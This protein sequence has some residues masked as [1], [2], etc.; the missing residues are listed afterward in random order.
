MNYRKVYFRLNSSYKWGS[1][2]S[3]EESVLFTKETREL[4]LNDGWTIKESSISNACDEFV[5][6]KQCLY[7]HPQSISGAVLET[8]I[9]KIETLL[10]NF[11]G[12]SFYYSNTD[13]YEIVFDYDDTQI[14]EILKER[15]NEI[16]TELLKLLTTKRKNSFVVV[17]LFD[18]ADKFKIKTITEHIGSSSSDINQIYIRE[19][20]AELINSGKIETA[21]TKHGL[22]YRT[23]K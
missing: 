23:V 12:K 18:F 15:R 8:N 1:G 13:I 3:N 7:C 20:L 14:L 2:F 11:K 6:D 4:F 9:E 19:I 17:N 22:G 21:E 5:K 16:E 10:K